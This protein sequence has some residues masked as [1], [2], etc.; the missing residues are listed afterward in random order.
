MFKMVYYVFREDPDG[1]LKC[2]SKRKR[3]IKGQRS[4]ALIKILQGW[5]ESIFHVVKARSLK[6]ALYTIKNHQLP[7][8]DISYHTFGEYIETI[9]IDETTLIMNEI[10]NLE[11]ESFT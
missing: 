7:Q 10:E 4:E 8:S 1:N 9:I 3:W 5:G 6:Q 11:E 2:V